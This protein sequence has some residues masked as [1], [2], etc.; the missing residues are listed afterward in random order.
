[1]GSQ[2]AEVLKA[3]KQRQTAFKVLLGEKYE[4]YDIVIAQDGGRPYEEHDIRR[5]LKH[6]CVENDLPVVVPH[7]MRHLSVT[8]KLLW[9]G[10]VKAVQADSGH[11]DAGM[12]YNRYSHAVDAEQEKLAM[13]VDARLYKRASG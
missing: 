13:T 10:D 6:L 2:L 3:E 1:M 7:A 8:L 11:K 4:D 12:V 9:S 5:H